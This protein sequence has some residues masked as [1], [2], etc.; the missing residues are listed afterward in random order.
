M[1]VLPLLTPKVRL[2]APRRSK[3]SGVPDMAAIDREEF[4]TVEKLA[5]AASRYVA[6]RLKVPFARN[7]DVVLAPV[8]PVK[9]NVAAWA[10][11]A[12]N[13]TATP[14]TAKTNK[15]LIRLF[16]RNRETKTA[17]RSRRCGALVC[18]PNTSKIVDV[19][20]SC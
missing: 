2:P 4:V 18:I 12:D 14:A 1:V 8:S 20:T 13:A 10:A 16:S 6:E 15:D 3:V 9:F 11:V 17:K 19:S 7:G 5:L